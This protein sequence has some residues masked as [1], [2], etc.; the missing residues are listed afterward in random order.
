MMENVLIATTLSKTVYVINSTYME[1]N[2][3]F[4]TKNA[5]V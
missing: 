3:Y 2:T 4:V 5:L 1:W